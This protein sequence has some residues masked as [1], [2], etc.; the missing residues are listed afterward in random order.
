MKIEPQKNSETCSHIN[1]LEELKPPKDYVCE[2]C[3]KENGQWVHLRTCQICGVTLCC[4]S[5]PHKHMT[6]H[7]HNTNHNVVISAEPQE[8]FIY[9]YT[10]KVFAKY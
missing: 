3:I 9:C 1:M 7:F 2:E 4:D 6:M 10:D 8:N 5:S